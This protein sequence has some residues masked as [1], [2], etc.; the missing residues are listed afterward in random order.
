MVKKSILALLFSVACFLAGCRKNCVNNYRSLNSYLKVTPERKVFKIGDTI[1]WKIVVPFNNIDNRTNENVNI[2]NTSKISRV[3]MTV[4]QIDKE[5]SPGV[6]RGGLYCFSITVERGEKP[7]FH[8]DHPYKDARIDFDFEKSDTEFEI[9]VVAIAKEKGTFMICHAPA[10]GT[11]NCI[12]NDFIP[13]YG[14]TE[15]NEDLYYK[16]AIYNAP[17]NFYGSETFFIVQ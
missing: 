4:V 5:E 15:R 12:I 10:S 11:D 2:R 9:A 14:N 3:Y 16:Y 6:Y 8:K 1:R 13:V 17:T 7:F